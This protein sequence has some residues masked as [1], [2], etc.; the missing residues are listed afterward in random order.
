[1]NYILIMIITYL[2]IKFIEPMFEILLEIFIC[3]CSK[4]IT[5]IKLK[6]Q[7]I[8]M[9]FI[10]EYPE[11]IEDEEKNYELQSLIGFSIDRNNYDDDED[12]Y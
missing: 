10:R 4:I 5:K 9:D 7:A 1:M 3:Y 6:E 2:F 12:E 11:T 8:T